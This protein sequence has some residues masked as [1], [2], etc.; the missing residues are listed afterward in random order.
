MGSGNALLQFGND[1]APF[2]SRHCARV[3]ACRA[4][5]QPSSSSAILKA[6]LDASTPGG[7]R[8]IKRAHRL[9]A[10]SS[11][12]VDPGRYISQYGHTAWRIQD[13]FLGGAANAIAQTTDG[14]LWIGTQAGLLRFDG[15]RFVPWTPP[16]WLGENDSRKDRAL[17][18][19]VWRPF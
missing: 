7:I 11:W 14:Y 15:I 9:G 8:L 16:D 3:D 2:C 5:C 13:G 18:S 12:A 1:M 4:K 10:V 17:G 6:H 19:R